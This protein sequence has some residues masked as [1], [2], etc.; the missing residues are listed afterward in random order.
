MLIHGARLDRSPK[1]GEEIVPIEVDGKTFNLRICI[2]RSLQSP[3]C[4]PVN[5]SGCN[6]AEGWQIYC[7]EAS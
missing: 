6:S 3:N 4:N 5:L 1:C 7:A 2:A